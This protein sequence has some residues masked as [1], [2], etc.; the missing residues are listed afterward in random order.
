MDSPAP[1]HPYHRPGRSRGG[2]VRRTRAAPGF[3][4]QTQKEPA[5]YPRGA[6]DTGPVKAELADGRAGQGLTGGGA[7]GCSLGA[8]AR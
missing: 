7:S 2:R 1:Y 3:G 5:R 6:G 8:P 4:A